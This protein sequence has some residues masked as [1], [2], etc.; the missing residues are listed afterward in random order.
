VS[1][2]LSVNSV[3]L[4]DAPEDAY[5]WYTPPG[6]AAIALV[7]VPAL[8]GLLDRE[9]PEPGA[10]RFAQLVD[11]AGEAVDEVVATRL[12]AGRLELATHAGP[13]IRAAIDQALV[14]HGLQASDAPAE[15]RWGRLAACRH[16]AALPA[17]LADGEPDPAVA[18]WADRVPTVLLAGPPNAGKSSLLNAWC[19]FAR[20]LVA[21]EPG[22]TRDLVAVEVE[23]RGW[24]L[25]LVDGAGLREGGDPVEARGRDLSRAVAGEADVVLWL[26]P[27]DEAPP[28]PRE[29]ALVILA[30]DDLRPAPRAPCPAPP[31][32]RFAA[33]DFV[34]EEHSRELLERLGDAVLAAL[35]LSPAPGP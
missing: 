12:E 3:S 17:L 26:E 10:A 14:A 7:E 28:P 13:G 19:G 9:L 25:R 5:F 29:D 4:S 11:P 23:H 18:R 16:R 22:T 32:L 8:T 31:D 34:G 20:A 27:P 2:V 15:D 35:G 21:A 33:P 24:R 30:K 6:P 1:S